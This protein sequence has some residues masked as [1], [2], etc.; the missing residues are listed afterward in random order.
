MVQSCIV[1]CA[2]VIWLW[3]GR[4]EV[5]K[6]IVSKTYVVGDWKFTPTRHELRRGD[7]RVK[8]EHRAAR[9]LQMLCE[10][11][12][13]VVARDELM[14][15]LWGARHVSRNSLAVVIGDLR[16]ALGDD[17][18]QPRFVETV[19]KSGY[20]LIAGERVGDGR[21]HRFSAPVDGLTWWA[22]AIT[23]GALLA[24]APTSTN[25][26]A[27]AQKILVEEIENATG[28]SG[29]D[30]LADASGAVMLSAVQAQPGWVVHRASRG[31]R[32]MGGGRSDPAQIR[33][34]ARLGLWT[35]QPDILLIAERGG[36]VVW[37]GHAF[38]PEPQMP[39]LIATQIDA[40]KTKLEAQ[41]AD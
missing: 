9:A 41:P 29:Y 4:A 35:G 22:V 23:A 10:H 33:L 34:S 40:L 18:R 13:E 8:L 28:E 14:T 38:G 20:R 39:A 36:A 11:R 16:R 3:A 21:G 24:L 27:G 2:A 31:D 15:C 1:G 30:A 37:T 26:T 25:Q 6:D 32:S 12:G 17:A 19:A 5:G 7:A